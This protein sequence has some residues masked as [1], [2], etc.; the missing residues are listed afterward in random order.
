MSF[1]S[2]AIES[3]KKARFTM[4]GHPPRM[5]SRA[6]CFGLVLASFQAAAAPWTISEEIRL[7]DWSEYEAVVVTSAGRLLVQGDEWGDAGFAASSLRIES[8]GRVELHD[9]AYVE[10]ET[11]E[12]TGGTLRV[13]AAS[14]S[15]TSEWFASEIH[16]TSGE[17][18]VEVGGRADSG[19]TVFSV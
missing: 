9:S 1:C 7:Q 18:V 2:Q 15:G 16:G 12:M 17:S 4:H 8:G 11:T 13:S 5:T 14:Q 3:A 6:A 19:T 10:V